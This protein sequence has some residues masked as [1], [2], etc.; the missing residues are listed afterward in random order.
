M[1]SADRPGSRDPPA[2]RRN[3]RRPLDAPIRHATPRPELDHQAHTDLKTP[4]FRTLLELNVSVLDVRRVLRERAETKEAAAAKAS[5][6]DAAITT[7]YLEGRSMRA[8]RI[9]LN[10]GYP[11]V[12]RALDAA[13][14]DRSPPK[15]KGWE[16]RLRAAR[17]RASSP[18]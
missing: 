3:E 18:R 2:H 15:G 1:V 11:R 16:T 14:I 17:M 9:D 5:L 12:R 13:G 4:K 10:I 8:I 7:A 6:V